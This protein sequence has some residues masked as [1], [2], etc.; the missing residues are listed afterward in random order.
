MLLPALL[1]RYIIQFVTIACLWKTPFASDSLRCFRTATLKANSTG[2]WKFL[3]GESSRHCCRAA[4]HLQTSCHDPGHAFSGTALR[5]IFVF[6]WLSSGSDASHFCSIRRASFRLLFD[7]RIPP[8]R[9]MMGR[10]RD[11]VRFTTHRPQ[12]Q[13][14]QP[15][16]PLRAY[17]CASYRHAFWNRLGATS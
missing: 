8:A 10:C 12:D 9:H 15:W 16:M 2:I 11:D 4:K 17:I 6:D 14:V 7:T 5:S 1:P 13:V 3:G